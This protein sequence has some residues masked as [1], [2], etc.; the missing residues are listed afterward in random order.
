MIFIRAS[1]DCGGDDYGYWF[2]SVS[3]LSCTLLAVYQI[4]LL[5]WKS[6]WQL[7][8]AHRIRPQSSLRINILLNVEYN[9]GC[10][11]GEGVICVLLTQLDISAIDSRISTHM[12][13]T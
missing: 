7:S 6:S 8:R 2:L 13:V 5:L 3:T 9:A 12:Y 11:T 1:C 10:E 4:D